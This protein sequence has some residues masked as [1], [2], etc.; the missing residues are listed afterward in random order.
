MAAQLADAGV[1]RCCFAMRS[2]SDERQSAS[3]AILRIAAYQLAWSLESIAGI[4][5]PLAS[6]SDGAV[7]TMTG[8]PKSRH[9]EAP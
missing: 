8:M 7:E 9:S 5:P 3:S 1:G 4:S 6:I 2:V